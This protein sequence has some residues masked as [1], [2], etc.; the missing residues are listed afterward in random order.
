[1]TTAASAENLMHALELQQV[2]LTSFRGYGDMPILA[3]EGSDLETVSD[4]PI[5]AS[6]FLQP[7]PR[8]H[9][10]GGLLSDE[11]RIC[12]ELNARIGAATAD[13]DKFSARNN[14]GCT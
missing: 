10:L 13:F 4:E 9:S 7:M 1:M 14:T 2:T 12:T 8:Y 3:N 6:K 5:H 11:G